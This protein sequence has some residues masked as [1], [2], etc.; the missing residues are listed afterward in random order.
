MTAF[1]LNFIKKSLQIEIYKFSDFFKIPDVS[2]QAFSKGRNKLSPK[3]FILLANK[4]TEEFYT[5]NAIREFKG[6]S[7]RVI[8]GATLALP[9]SEELEKH[10]GKLSEK[11]H[12]PSAKI[13]VMYDPLNKM[14]L[15]GLIEPAKSSERDLAMIHLEWSKKQDIF[16][17]EEFSEIYIFD[18]GYPSLYLP[19]YGIVNKKHILM[20][21][22]D[23]FLKET[24]IAIKNGLL[25]QI[26]TI[27]ISDKSPEMKKMLLRYIPDL[28]MNSKFEMRLLNFTLP[29]GE[30]EYI[31][32]TLTDQI[33]FT[34]EDI[35]KLYG[36]RWDGEENYKFYKYITEIEN[37]SGESVIAVQQEFYATIF[38]C[39]MAALLMQEA[40]DELA[41]KEK[42]PEIKYEYKPNRN[43]LIGIMKNDIVDILLSDKDI[44]EYC[45]KMKR[46]I[47]K[48]LVPIRPNRKNPRNFKVYVSS[49]K[50]VKRRAL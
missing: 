8:D 2:K 9:G 26:I 5:D 25:D 23:S 28:D 7:L 16:N 21:I 34:S 20:R 44:N 41:A 14:T 50:K 15:H 36:I 33:K 35:F 4:M 6:M 1:I 47:K 11:N 10:F 24:N 17:K 19:I 48:D 46:R 31:L 40:E 42:N 29:S 49:L 39:N 38:T 22:T 43:T 13:S 27:S 30:K 45:E 37:F 18:R 12:D 32:T 3:V